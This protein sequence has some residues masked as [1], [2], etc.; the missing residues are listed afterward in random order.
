[1]GLANRIVVGRTN[2]FELPEQV[3]SQPM[4]I[5]FCSQMEFTRLSEG[6][7]MPDHSALWTR[8]SLLKTGV[9]AGAAAVT[10]RLA[11]GTN[12]DGGVSDVKTASQDLPRIVAVGS[13]RE[14]LLLDFNWRF[15]LGDA[16][17]AEKDFD[18]GKLAREATFAK[19]GRAGSV[20]YLKF[21]DST[22][23]TIDLPHDWGVELPFQ[24]T[25]ALLSEHGAKPLGRDY[26]ETSIGWYRRVI[27][28]PA[29]DA[30]KRISIEFDGAFRQA[31]VFFNGFY[32]GTNFSGYAP[33]SFDLTDF[34]NPGERNILTVRVDASFSES[35][36][37]EGAG[38]YRHVWLVKTA[39]V[40][41]SPWSQCIRSQVKTNSAAI[42][43]SA[44]VQND[45]DEE[46]TCRLVTTI[47]APH[48][49]AITTAASA[50][51]Q[52]PAFSVHH[53]ETATSISNPVL[54]SVAA[55]EGQ[56]HLYQA[57]THVH[58]GDA[59]V[60]QETTS[61]GIRTLSWDADYGFFLNGKP[62]KIKGTCNHQDHAGVGT[63]MPDRMQRYRLERLQEMGSNAYRTAHNPPSP[64][65]LDA[66]DEFGIV[67]MCETRIFSSS[68]EGL[69]ELERMVL[70]FRNH[71][72][73]ILWS[74]GNEEQEQGSLRGLNI[75]ATMRQRVRELDPTRLVILPMNGSW[76]DGASHS[77]D[78]QG[79]N[80]FNGDMDEFHRRMP[81]QP[82][83]GSEIGSVHCTRGIY[84]NDTEHGY[85]SAYDRNHNSYSSTA[86][87][88]WKYFEAR[89]WLAGGFIWAGFDYRGEPKPYSYPTVSCNSGIFDTCGFPKDNYYYYRA[90][91]RQEPLL[92]LFPHWNWEGK[93]GQEIEV[94]CHCNLDSVE[95]FLNG[96]TLGSQSVVR[97]SHLSWKVNYAPGV[98][99]AR[100]SKDDKILLVEKRE[101]TAAP[102]R[103]ALRADRT[104]ISYDAEDVA[105]LTVE[106]LDSQAR[107]VP[108][109]SNLISFTLS[110]PGKINGVGNGD[111]SCLEP[112]KAERRSAFNG[113]C[114]A[115]V[116]SRKESGALV[117]TAS[118]PGLQPASV[119]IRSEIP[120]ARPFVE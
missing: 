96:R 74:I 71:P 72:S 79:F 112:D 82:C 78:V 44:D 21:D 51:V 48:G 107:V 104:S 42:S 85:F 75:A 16:G 64:E 6:R 114:M 68:S 30:G 41:I 11:S 50:P 87:E 109:A 3:N 57:I 89:H 34:A 100:G 69:S 65:L 28:L 91:W 26:P 84:E 18:F 98:L 37:Y 62:L 49:K 35:W 47:L 110:G 54:W 24:S 76:G 2:C 120:V 9:C 61:F 23:R 73:V 39:P 27:M 108:T 43:V 17:N 60:D 38:I 115:I 103:L 19:S 70:R 56:K 102:A 119:T 31:A 10:A 33:F 7:V 113:L 92:H 101:T 4:S 52:V 36:Y 97:N 99:E 77:I 118:S 8:R 95:L 25:P 116:Q 15:H 58:I 40:H 13:L 94:W 117:F 55:G 88:W 83:V 45:T 80:Y 90:W 93:E 22:W 20:T 12:F 5:D 1:V 106:I 66:C 14:R 59:V 63:A 81:H 46:K 86:E 105:I 53:F 32:L 67:V 29:S 111:P